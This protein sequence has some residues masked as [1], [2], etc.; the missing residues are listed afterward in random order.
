MLVKGHLQRVGMLT[1]RSFEVLMSPVCLWGAAWLTCMPNVG[2]C[3][4]LGEHSTRCYHRIVWSVGLPWYWGMWNVGKVG[5]LWNYLDE[6][7]IKVWSQIML[8]L[9]GCWN[10]CASVWALEDGTWL[11]NRSF[12]VV[13]AQM[14]LWGV[15]WLICMPNVGA[16]RRVGKC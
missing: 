12:K 1:N 6:F 16:W 9:W 10:V 2:A 13:V 15:A 4:M 5:R 8:L 11:I 3:R 7:T 14:C